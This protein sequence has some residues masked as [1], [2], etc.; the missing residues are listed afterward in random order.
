KPAKG[1]KQK[2]DKQRSPE[3]KDRR[4]ADRGMER[5]Y[6]NAGKNDG[7]YAGNLIDIL[8]HAVSGQRVDVGR[9]DLMRGYSLFDVKKSDAK[10]VVQALTGFDFVGNKLFA[11]IADPEKDYSRVSTRRKKKDKEA[12]GQKHGNYDKFIKKGKRKK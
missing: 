3:E 11:E 4:T 10:R 6:V 1:K 12:Q 9:I 2:A 5:I 8:N 7:F